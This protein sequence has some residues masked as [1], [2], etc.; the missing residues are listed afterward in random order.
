MD[1]SDRLPDIQGAIVSF[2]AD[3]DSTLSDE[4]Q[5]ACARQVR[6]CGSAW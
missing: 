5:S 2:Q 4:L 6:D 3:I 1:G